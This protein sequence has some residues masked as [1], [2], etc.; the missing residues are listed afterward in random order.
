M[1]KSSFDIL[2]RSHISFSPAPASGLLVLLGL[3]SEDDLDEELELPV[4]EFALVGCSH[5]VLS[6]FVDLGLHLEV[7]LLDVQPVALVQL[8][9]DL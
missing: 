4:E 8:L 6:D 3:L 5:V 1:Q 9:K 2:R 7:L